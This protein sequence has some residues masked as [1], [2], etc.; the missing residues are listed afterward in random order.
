M[1]LSELASLA[2]KY[3]EFLNEQAIFIN[4]SLRSPSTHMEINIFIYV[5]VIAVSL[6]N[7]FSSVDRE[8]EM[9]LY[10]VH[11]PPHSASA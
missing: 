5:Y 7:V 4:V 3:L 9:L 8:W 10:A 11:T 2:V 6:K 1:K